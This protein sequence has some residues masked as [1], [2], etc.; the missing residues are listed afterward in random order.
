M[1]LKYEK[2]CKEACEDKSNP[3]DKKQAAKV[4]N[5]IDGQKK[6]VRKKKKTREKRNIVFNSLEKMVEDGAFGDDTL[7]TASE[8]ALEKLIHDMDLAKLD[9]C[10]AK[11]SDD[12]RKIILTIYGC[13]DKK[14]NIK[15]AAEQLGMK[16]TT[17]SDAHKRILKKLKNDFFM[18]EKK[19]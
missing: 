5:Y 15:R 4:R 19:S 2:A 7:G 13:D 12:D 17:V 16:R 9:E 11:L 18:E 1:I 3:M 6:K 14:V 8:D 10:L